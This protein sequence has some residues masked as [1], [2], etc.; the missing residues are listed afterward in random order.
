MISVRT[1]PSKLYKGLNMI[2]KIAMVIH[3]APPNFKGNYNRV[4]TYFYK[5]KKNTCLLI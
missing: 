4:A 2:L 5:I 1:T 3:F